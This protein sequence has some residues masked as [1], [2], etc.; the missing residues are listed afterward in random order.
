MSRER[1]P[2]AAP[3]SDVNGNDNDNV[4]VE[5]TSSDKADGDFRVVTETDYE[6]QGSPKRQRAGVSEEERMALKEKQADKWRQLFGGSS[7]VKNR[8]KGGSGEGSASGGSVFPRR[9]G[10]DGV[11]MRQKQD[12]KLPNEHISS[13][14]PRVVAAGFSETSKENFKKKAFWP[15][16]EPPEIVCLDDDDDDDDAVP[17]PIPGK[18]VDKGES[19][20]KIPSWLL[21]REVV[22]N[23]SEGSVSEN[24]DDVQILDSKEVNN[25]LNPPVLQRESTHAAEP[26]EESIGG[27]DGSEEDSDVEVSGAVV[28]EDI[29]KLWEEAAARRKRRRVCELSGKSDGG[30]NLRVN[31]FGDVTATSV[32]KG[33]GEDVGS[34]PQAT[35]SSHLKQ[36]D[37]DR[38]AENGDRSPGCSHGGQTAQPNEAPEASGVSASS[39][40]PGVPS[41][42]FTSG[43]TAR[44]KENEKASKAFAWASPP[45]VGPNNSTAGDDSQEACRSPLKHPNK[46]RAAEKGQRNPECFDGGKTA[47]PNETHEA[48]R[49]PVSSSS[50]GVASN[51]FT[52]G[53]TPRQKEKSSKAFA[54]V[55]PSGMGPNSTAGDDSLK[56]PKVSNV[57]EVYTWSS[58]KDGLISAMAHER[59]GLTNGVHAEAPTPPTQGAAEVHPSLDERKENERRSMNGEVGDDSKAGHGAEQKGKG[60][61]TSETKVV[62]QDELKGLRERM[63]ES[64]EFQRADE[65]EWRRRNEELQRQALEARKLRERKRAE[66]SKKLEIEAKQ[67]QRVADVRT[68]LQLNEST[69]DLKER[70]RG[71]ILP[72]LEGLARSCYDMASLLRKLDVTIEGGSNPTSAQVLTA[73]KKANL[74]FHPDRVA[75]YAKGDVRRLVE[76]EEAFKII[77]TLKATLPLISGISGV[78]GYHHQGLF[79]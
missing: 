49:V 43:V 12:Q 21:K 38:A 25:S 65:E 24:D 17:V 57:A 23:P 59:T 13:K 67:R 56:S 73:I 75:K 22:K 76:A 72:R 16:V 48:S 3:M 45:G 33:Q 42:R 29:R 68:Q 2:P 27:D 46:D 60:L 63:K 41:N 10:P 5:G 62:C 47:Q 14:R 31:E 15:S 7:K 51:R 20:K 34:V 44:Q 40:P 11:S 52:S 79:R 64:H 50:P 30:G 55:S 6:D 74:K 4:D 78:P 26:K 1:G 77:N 70:E 8:S 36:P 66:E 18:V 28:Q 58:V 35:C 61:V 19:E 69:M 39:S 32:N 54:P 37:G 53:V 9:N 71:R